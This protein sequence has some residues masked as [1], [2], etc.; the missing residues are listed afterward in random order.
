M[1][2][3]KNL[4]N[5]ICLLILFVI[6][7]PSSLQ[8]Q[9]DS[10]ETITE[11]GKQ[12]IIHTVEK[13]NTLYSL[14]RKYDVS[15]DELVRLNPIAKQGLNPGQRLKIPVPD[16]TE[17]LIRKIELDGNYI[18]HE[19]TPKQTLYS[20]SKM[21]HVEIK[22]IVAENQNAIYGIQPGD[23]LRIPIDKIVKPVAVKDKTRDKYPDHYVKPGETLYSISK[24]YNV[25]I[26]EIE[27]LNDGLPDGLKEG[28]V[29]N[30]PLKNADDYSSEGPPQDSL[31]LRQTYHIG[32]FLPL[33]IDLNDSL[34]TEIESL[35]ESLIYGGKNT[36]AALHFY[37]GVVM[38]LDSMGKA[39]FKAVLHV[40]DTEKD[41]SV[42]NEYINSNDFKRLDL[43]M[44]PLYP[45][46]F[47][48]VLE[49]AKTEGIRI[50]SPIN[51]S[52]RP[53]L[54]N[55]NLIKVVTSKTT[56]IVDLA[57]YISINYRHLNVVCIKKDF[58]DNSM[59]NTFLDNYTEN[60]LLIEDSTISN[61]AR[62]YSC[63]SSTKTEHL[64]ALLN[65]DT[66][67]IVFLPF[68]D[69]VFVSNMV[70]K[71]NSLTK[72]YPITLIG[73][74]EW[75]KYDNIDLDYFNH[76]N[77]HVITWN[78]LDYENES[79]LKFVSDYHS[80]FGSFPG[81]FG[82]K[83]YDLSLYLFGL[84][85]K[86]GNSFLEFIEKYPRDMSSY[87]FKFCQTGMESGFENQS[88][89]ILRYKDYKLTRV[90]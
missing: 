24:M 13:G 56:Q 38:A 58:V 41:T 43:I 76:L 47:N 48:K 37:Q 77:L 81:E 12:F 59:A 8:A 33:F 26:E 74:E 34:E 32:L 78:N 21:Y 39:G 36:A 35:D 60:L 1:G 49:A 75:L 54:G 73:L 53:L 9:E 16:K 66:Q 19:V 67:N 18:A 44:G 61:P 62:S 50:V 85:H 88:L 7:L 3:I 31:E 69:K 20:I 4:K 15:V 57:K 87:S 11:G 40:I 6:V 68:T 22:D 71:L 84:M 64:K 10:V 5:L 2:I 86:Y 45:S 17:Q 79:T 27:R 83:G 30:I 65:P 72:D 89:V 14:S 23:I 52:N 70:K 51:P 55:E 25:S 28:E 42:I 46:L 63:N 80:N 82:N 29:I 90:Y